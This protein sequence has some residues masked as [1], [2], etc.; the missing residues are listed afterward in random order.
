MKLASQLMLT[1]ALAAV[2]LLTGNYAKAG[3]ISGQ[4]EFGDINSPAAVVT[5]G[6]VSPTNP[7]EVTTGTGNYAGLIGD[8][9]TFDPIVFAPQTTGLLWT[10]VSGATTYTFTINS[11]TSTFQNGYFVNLAGAG[12]ATDAEASPSAISICAADWL[13][14]TE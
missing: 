3:Y 1:S 4:I 8:A 13:A 12:T 10:I 5:L 7:A 6:E 9:A 2:V 11:F 14:I